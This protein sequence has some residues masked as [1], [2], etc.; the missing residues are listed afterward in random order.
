MWLIKNHK[1]GKYYKTKYLIDNDKLCHLHGLPFVKSGVLTE[2]ESRS[3]RLCT[4]KWPQ[5]ELVGRFDGRVRDWKHDCDW[6]TW[7]V[8][9]DE[10]N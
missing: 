5:I 1:T 10:N 9:I 7:L 2:E 8:V 3:S 4:D 6:F